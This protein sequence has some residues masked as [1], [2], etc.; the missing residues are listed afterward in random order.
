M[1]LNILFIK[2]N[3]SL[4]ELENYKNIHYIVISN[5]LNTDTYIHL[6]QYKLININTKIL[7][8]TND[9]YYTKNIIKNA[10]DYGCDGLF[11]NCINNSLDNVQNII[12]AI[13]LLPFPYNFKWSFIISNVFSISLDSFSYAKFNILN[14]KPFTKI[15][16][17]SNHLDIKNT[18]HILYP[19]S[20]IL[21]TIPPSYS[22]SCNLSI[23]FLT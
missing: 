21:N 5:N 13:S 2:A 23:E 12:N 11:I 6:Y 14:T 15:S 9:S 20:N 18:N 17:Y 10:M 4:H 8:Y 19:S 3:I 1:D 7:Y 22:L 16:L